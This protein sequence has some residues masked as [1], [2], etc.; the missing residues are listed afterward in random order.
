MRNH[1][2][3]CVL[4][5]G[6]FYGPDDSGLRCLAFDTGE[7]KWTYKEFGKGSLM[8]AGGKLVALS[9]R[10]VLIIAEPTPAE[11]KP[12]S[13]AKILSGK[14]WTMPVLS[15]GHIYFRNAVGDVVCL[16]VSGK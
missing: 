13:R 10:G 5:K 16:D 1:F 2:N 6:F 11:F 15:N 12:I 14:C 3:T 7:L 9:E 4:W 8:L